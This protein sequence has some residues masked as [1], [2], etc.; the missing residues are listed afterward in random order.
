MHLDACKCC[1]VR[2]CILH[3][4]NAKNYTACCSVGLAKAFYMSWVEYDLLHGRRLPNH[5][6]DIY[7]TSCNLNGFTTNELE[8]LNQI[9][10][11][12]N[13]LSVALLCA[14]SFKS[15]LDM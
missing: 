12:E 5:S 9:P 13:E 10:P 14:K 11:L 15:D 6:T 3:E 8:I 4:G 2:N 1:P 7:P